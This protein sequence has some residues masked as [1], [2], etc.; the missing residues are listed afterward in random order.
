MTG[1][2]DVYR[3]VNTPTT[4]EHTSEYLRA[5]IKALEQRV[6]YLEAVIEVELLN[7]NNNEYWN[8]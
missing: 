8:N 6:K 5:R 1:S 7:H 2:E 4:S 3:V